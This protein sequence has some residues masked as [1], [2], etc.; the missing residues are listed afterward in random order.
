MKQTHSEL[1]FSPSM[2]ARWGGGE[3]N[4][5]ADS[6]EHSLLEVLIAFPFQ[7]PKIKAWLLLSGHVK[8]YFVLRSL[9][10]VQYVG[11]GLK[12][13]QNGLAEMLSMGEYL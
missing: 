8:K 3:E 4:V 12:S 5:F 10:M 13:N 11:L 6:S 1:E 2:K 7:I 9:N